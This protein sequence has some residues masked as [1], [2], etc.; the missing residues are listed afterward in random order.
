MVNIDPTQQ[1]DSVFSALADPTRR[2]MLQRLSEKDMSVAELAEPFAMSKPAISKHLKVLEKAGLL[3]REVLG[4]VHR[5][6]LQLQPLS[7]AAQW[8]SFYERFWNA[9]LD[10]L[11]QYLLDSAE[12]K[13]SRQQRKKS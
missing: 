2:A 4:R 7:Q 11:D 3:R 6:Q 9:K 10:A 13:G 1:L 5:C 12:A 8:L